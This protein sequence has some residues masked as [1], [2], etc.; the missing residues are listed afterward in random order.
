MILFQFQTGSIRRSYVKVIKSSLA[1]GFNSKLVR[2]EAWC[3]KHAQ[4]FAGGFNSKLVRLEDNRLFD[5]PQTDFCF[6]S[7]LVRLEVKLKRR[8]E[9]AKMKFQFQTG[10]IRS[11]R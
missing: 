3:L 8:L 4:S 6:N 9:D 10:S 11:R 1:A 2:L 7:K 5:F